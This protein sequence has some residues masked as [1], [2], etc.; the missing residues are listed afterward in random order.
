MGANTPS[1][2]IR[3]VVADDDQVV[4]DN[5][6]KMLTLEDGIEIV[7]VGHD[8]EEAIAVAAESQPDVLL[9]D[10]NMPRGGGVRA[11]EGV[12]AASPRTHVIAHSA[13]EDRGAVMQMVRAGAIG[14]IVK[15]SST[16]ELI[17]VVRR[18]AAG[19]AMLS[20]AI[21]ST[22]VHELATL[23]R[24]R[25]QA[26]EAQRAHQAIFR[27]F[28]GGE[29]MSILFQP[30]ME[31]ATGG[32]VGYEAL[33]RFDRD[34]ERSPRDWFDEAGGV[35][36]RLE[37]ESAAISE[38][39]AALP[40][41]PA[42]MFL[43]VNAAPT[44]IASEEL[45]RLLMGVPPDRLVVDISARDREYDYRAFELSLARLRAR[46]VRLAV[47][48]VG[49]SDAG[50]QHLLELA[51]DMVKLDRAIFGGIGGR[52]AFK[53]MARALVKLGHDTGAVVV[54]EGVESPEE[55]EWVRS[56]GVN[57][58]QGF[59]FGR[60]EALAPTASRAG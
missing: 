13:Y 56:L 32:C 10:V 60:P 43:E 6:A 16:D 29:G 9:T 53:A 31:L 59:L 15:G 34:P 28:I 12:R 8:A 23:L 11:T 50:L 35:G 58:G 2:P 18:A 55:L 57:L 46:G 51:P 38:A 1:S 26:A 36:F 39:L 21:T 17:E 5:V 33:A 22:V 4:L 40:R 42:P 20:H 3:L 24:Q 37:L 54:A 49:A 44:T 45:D 52:P 30:V 41:I 14:Y 25:E 27:R 48:D 47:D 19:E 7:A